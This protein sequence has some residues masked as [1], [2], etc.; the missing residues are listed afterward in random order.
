M[1]ILPKPLSY[2]VR[3]GRFDLPPV[4]R[5]V[6]PQEWH[7][8]L[9]FLLTTISA[10]TGVQFWLDADWDSPDMVFEKAPEGQSAEHYRLSVDSDR[11]D[12]A[13][14]GVSGALYAIQTLRQLLPPQYARTTVQ[15]LAQIDCCVVEDA[16]ALS[17]RGL[18]LDVSRHFFGK[19]WILRLLD[20]MAQVKLNVLH[21]HLSDDQGWRVQIDA[22]P[23]LTAVGAYRKQTLRGP[24]FSK[25]YD[26]KPHGGFFTKADVAEIVQYAARLGIDVVPE[27]DMP[28]HMGAAIAAYPEWGVTG[29]QIDVLT[30]WA[31][32]F[33]VLNLED[34]TVDAMKIILDEIMEMFPSQYI[35]IGGDECPRDQWAQ[36]D[37]SAALVK[38][39]NLESVED[40]QPWFTQQLSEHIQS[41][42]R[43]MVGWDEVLDDRL[44]KDDVIMAWRSPA[45]AAES[46]S[47]GFP[48]VYAAQQSF[49]FDFK[50]SRDPNEP[51]GPR[52]FDI[53]LTELAEVYGHDWYQE[54]DID[55]GE[56]LL[57]GAQAELWTE[58]VPNSAQAE[59]MLFPRLLA[60][61]DRVWCGSGGDFGEFL[62][63]MEPF[64]ERLEAQDVNYRPMTGPSQDQAS[65][66]FGIENGR[67]PQYLLSSNDSADNE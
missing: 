65:Q 16:P 32:T 60:F 54:G 21:L 17:W 55:P 40:L 1:N 10:S 24:R 42:G 11:I 58:F 18:M 37:R 51:L 39:R 8:S 6:A 25:E 3:Q 15:G 4:M 41:R 49:Y 23:R 26:G 38:Q 22:F 5:T 46:I 50:Q 56:S 28:G 14:G 30:R 44:S 61:A 45:M 59:Y 43:T 52:V 34:S 12:I 67:E 63:R 33:D 53:Y 19:A 47:R 29:E 62:E 20:L 31:R 35:H 2:E 66:W 57:L 27:I 48:T 9:S 7:Q 13:A 64:L 36:S